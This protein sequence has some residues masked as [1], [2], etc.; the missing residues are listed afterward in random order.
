LPF[1]LQFRKARAVFVERVPFY[2]CCYHPT[3]IW[4]YY[5]K[6]NRTEPE[7]IGS[8]MGNP[9]KPQKS[10]IAQF[11]RRIAGNKGWTLNQLCYAIRE[12]AFKNQRAG[13]VGKQ[14]LPVAFEYIMAMLYGRK[15]MPHRWEVAAAAAAELTLEAYQAEKLEAAEAPRKESKNEVLPINFWPHFAW[16]SKSTSPRKVAALVYGLSGRHHLELSCSVIPGQWKAPPGFRGYSHLRDEAWQEFSRNFLRMKKEPPIPK[17]IWHVSRIVSDGKTAIDFNVQQADFR[18]ILI[19][20]N[21]QGL[22]LPVVTDQNEKCRVQDWLAG[23]WE[24]GNPSKPVLPGACQLVVDLMVITKEGSAVLSRQGPD[25]PDA[26]GSWCPSVSTVVNPKMD[27]DD[28]QLPDLIR[29]VSR[30]CKEELGLETDGTAVQWLGVAAGLKY[31]SFTA[32]GMLKTSRTKQEIQESVAE[33]LKKIKR[34]P[35][36]VIQVTSVEFLALT[37]EKIAA[38]LTAC[39]YRPYLELGLALLLW[40]KGEAEILDGE[41]AGALRT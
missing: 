33:N 30:G 23:N 41:I 25:N 13:E 39:D 29:A 8:N 1:K 36:H 10:S 16:K 7:I 15:P 3:V 5:H 28:T 32:F 18:D 38:R 26:A 9:Q 4:R 22:N 24:P 12:I 34:D 27:S 11:H 19:T 35:T 37:P 21:Y 40:S 2:F 20:G 17:P 31:G 6:G 14:S